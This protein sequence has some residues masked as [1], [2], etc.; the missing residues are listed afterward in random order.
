LQQVS[1]QLMFISVQISTRLFQYLVV[2][3]RFRDKLAQD[4]DLR[5]VV[6]LLHRDFLAI[7]ADWLVKLL[8][9]PRHKVLLLICLLFKLVDFWLKL[10]IGLLQLA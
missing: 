5:F 8:L 1:Y 3:W 6:L 10:G 9:E 7:T 4:V 2:F